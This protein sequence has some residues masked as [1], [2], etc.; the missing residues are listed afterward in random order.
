MGYWQG[1][2]YL[3]WSD[4]RNARW[5]N[6]FLIIFVVYLTLFS[7]KEIVTIVSDANYESSMFLA[8]YL[9]I[10][11]F[12]VMGLCTSHVYGF[13]LKK[14]LLS[15]RLTYWRSLPIKIDQIVW[16]RVIGVTMTS[17]IA[18]AA[19]YALLA[20]LMFYNDYSF[21]IIPYMLHGLTVYAIIYFF[22]L[23]YLYAEMGNSYKQY[24]IYCWVAPF[25]KLT[26]ILS[27]NLIWKISI[28]EQL[29][30]AVERAPL[31]MVAASMILIAASYLLAFR[32]INSRVRLRN[33]M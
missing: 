21:Q 1:I 27:L 11:V 10:T 13:G 28:L 20:W 3:I 2:R 22:N 19:Y 26:L 32:L 12:S 23:V 24:L 31:I 16:A 25:A 17:L 4:I 7:Y 9:I 18:F 8:D 14:D 15:E 33:I 6:L 30:V 29:Y 5:K